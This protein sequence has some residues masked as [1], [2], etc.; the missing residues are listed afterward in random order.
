MR[1]PVALVAEPGRARATSR[2]PPPRLSQAGFRRF[3]GRVVGRFPRYDRCAACRDR[4][5]YRRTGARPGGADPGSVRD[6][7]GATDQRTWPAGDRAGPEPGPQNR[8]PLAQ[9]TSADDLVAKALD[10]DTLL[11]MHKPYLHQRWDQGCRD[12]TV[13]HAELTQR[14]YRGSIRTLYRFLQPFRA[15]DPSQAAAPVPAPPPKIRHVTTWL[16]RRPE[17]LDDTAQA[18]LADIRAACPHLDR[19]GDHITTFAKMMIHRTGANTLD[20]WLAAAEADDIP[21]LHTFA[22]GI[23]QDYTAVRNGLTLPHNSGA[24]EGTV[25]KLKTIKRQMYGRASFSLLRKR[26]LLHA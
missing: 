3:S 5:T 7:S 24:C 1:G 9:A 21:E 10:R 11:D 16:L 19:L 23:R 14:G 26:I 2:D 4:R 15:L 18:A 17:D 13:L 22:R 25:N 20:T 6:H 8:P 12:V